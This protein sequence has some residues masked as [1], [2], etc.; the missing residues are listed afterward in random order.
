MISSLI[1]S[2]SG[3]EGVSIS[4]NKGLKLKFNE[5]QCTPLLINFKPEAS[6]LT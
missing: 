5:Q 1:S 6:S 2:I 3:I 4:Y